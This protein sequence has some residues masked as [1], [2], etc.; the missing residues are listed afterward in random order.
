MRVLRQHSERAAGATLIEVVVF[1][2]VVG[3]ALAAV[4]NTFSQHI[5]SVN[6]PLIR[7]RALALVQAQLDDVLARKFDENTPTGG[8]PACGSA[9]GVACLG[10]SSDAD[11]DDVGDFNGFTNTVDGYGISVVV[12]NAGSELGIPNAQAR[13]ISVT[14]TPPAGVGAMVISAYKVNF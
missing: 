10:I 6:T 3:I 1:M 4:V 8:V 12:V 14:V 2:V 13:R 9:A 7:I 11:Y 5:S